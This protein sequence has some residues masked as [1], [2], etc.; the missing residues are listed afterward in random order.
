L[1]TVTDSNALAIPA[2]DAGTGLNWLPGSNDA[3][4]IARLAARRVEEMQTLF[5]YSPTRSTPPEAAGRNAM[6]SCVMRNDTTS[7]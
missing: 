2:D 3:L 4:A 7:F 6:G 5:C 1:H